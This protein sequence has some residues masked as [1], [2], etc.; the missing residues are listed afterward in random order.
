MKVDALGSSSTMPTGLA[1]QG[2]IDAR[3]PAR[4]TER[5]ATPGAMNEIGAFDRRDPT[6]G[7]RAAEP[8]PF[9]LFRALG[10]L[11]GGARHPQANGPEAA[12]RFDLLALLASIF[13]FAGQQSQKSHSPPSDSSHSTP[14]SRGMP[15]EAPLQ[16][17]TGL[18]PREEQGVKV[19]ERVE[20]QGEAGDEHFKVKGRAA[21]EAHARADSFSQTFVDGSGV[22][23]RGGAEAS[24]GASAEAEGSLKTDIGSIDG[25][26]KVS[27][28]AYARVN[29]E[30]KA[31][32]Q[33]LSASGKAETGVMAK[34]EAET[35]LQLGDGLV[36]GHADA[37][38]EAGAG[39]KATGKVGVS[40]SPP[41][42]VVR[43]KAESFAGARAGYSAKGGVA[44][45]G[46]GIEAEVWAG[47]GVKAEVNGGLDGDGKF[48][49]E[50]S[51]G[52]AMGVGAMVKFNLEIDTKVIAKTV[53]KLLGGMGDV[54]GGLLGA[55]AGLF[56]GGKGDGAHAGNAIAGAV[57]GLAPQAGQL[58]GSALEQQLHSQRARDERNERADEE[59]NSRREAESKMGGGQ[60]SRSDWIKHSQTGIL[61]GALP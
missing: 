55:V 1:G 57:K 28:E 18:P 2:A 22:G 54:V 42:A 16:K 11:F 36:T 25:R 49:L 53:G 15:R 12:N 41:E 14:E 3:M 21:A 20:I 50:F 51:F 19:E 27:A 9:D 32:P 7:S 29:G 56:N 58:A 38:A 6:T 43:A 4:E 23:V 24:V 37:H 33:G 45:V 30:A 60:S 52:V 59:A 26:A 48:K 13:D 34:G 8:A 31:G 40:F 17:E 44:G 5:P 10:D 47:A 39:G 61:Q 35:N 46:Y